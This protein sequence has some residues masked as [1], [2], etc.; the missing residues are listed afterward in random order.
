M[1]FENYILPIVDYCT[2]T[3]GTWWSACSDLYSLNTHE[4]LPWQIAYIWLWIKS[5]LDR[6]FHAKIYERSST[7][8]KWISLVNKVWIIDSDY[9]WE[10]IA[11]FINTTDQTIVVQNWEKICQFEIVKNWYDITVV[12]K[13]EFE[14]NET[15]R[16][17]WWFG[18]TW[19]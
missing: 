4:I 17:E 7:H 9:R 15:E 8:K 18:S 2:P 16:W 12:S 5:Q 1:D 13:E 3:S 19:N 11:W 6:R 14:L 10:W